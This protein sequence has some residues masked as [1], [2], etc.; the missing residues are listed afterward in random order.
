[1][2]GSIT[3]FLFYA[4]TLNILW[5]Q[6]EQLLLTN[7]HNIKEIRFEFFLRIPICVYYTPATSETFSSMSLLV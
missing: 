7:K 6:D 1:M 2:P 5:H 4:C 3:S